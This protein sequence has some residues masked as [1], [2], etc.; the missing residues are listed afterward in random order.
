MFFIFWMVI[1][2]KIGF[3]ILYGCW[4]DTYFY[5]QY[6]YLGSKIFQYSFVE[7]CGL[8]IYLR[9]KFN[10]IDFYLYFYF[11][12]IDLDDKEKVLM[13]MFVCGKYVICRLI[14]VVFCGNNN[15]M[16]DLDF[17]G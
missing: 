2:L 12:V 17:Y 3:V 15:R 14:F 10:V 4:Y 8:F 13:I 9:R 16:Y 6:F 5:F 1:N 7:I 11:G